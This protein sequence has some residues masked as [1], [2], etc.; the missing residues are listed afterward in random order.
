MMGAEDRAGWLRHAPARARRHLH[1]TDAA[2]S[3]LQRRTRDRWPRRG[4]PLQRKRDAGRGYA[5]GRRPFRSAGLS[6]SRR[7]LVVPT[8]LSQQR[9]SRSGHTVKAYHIFQNGSATI[10]KRSICVA[11][12]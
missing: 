7:L 4:V 6:G 3:L 9:V 8:D 1:P 10:R 12:G 11:S 2:R 5:V